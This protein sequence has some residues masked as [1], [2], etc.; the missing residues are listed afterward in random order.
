[1]I[2]LVPRVSRWLA[3]YQQ[4]LIELHK[5]IAEQNDE[6]PQGD[7]VR[8]Q[9]D[10]PWRRMTPD[11]LY[12]VRGLSEDLYSITE[13]PVSAATPAVESLDERL[14]QMLIG[15]DWLGA[16]QFVREHAAGIPVGT[17][18][19]MR[20]Y[21][22]AQLGLYAAAAEFFKHAIRLDSSETFNRRLLLSTFLL[23][24]N[25]CDALSYAQL[26]LH[27]AT[28]PKLTLLIAEV[29]FIS[30]AHASETDQR[31]RLH[32][33]AIGAVENVLTDSTLPSDDLHALAVSGWL[34]VAMSYAELDDREKALAAWAKAEQLAP[35]DLNVFLVSGYLRDAQHASRETQLDVARQLL[36]APARSQTRLPFV[37]AR[38]ETGVPS[39]DTFIT[40]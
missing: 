8:D 31:D 20:G 18:A 37:R 4:L 14:R 21:C 26:W 3:R 23:S 34:H 13:S 9:M 22:W 12:L 5:L 25:T 24:G 30:A 17:A 7:D 35:D 19:S 32:R 11:E 38:F 33:Q 36:V 16:L 1:M 28:D 27:E 10:L 6:G 39:T 2:P 29:L 40:N 15:E